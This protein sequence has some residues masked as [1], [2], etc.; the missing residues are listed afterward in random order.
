VP[1]DNCKGLSK[2]VEK[3]SAMEGFYAVKC[4]GET[5]PLIVMAAGYM[6]L[7]HQD[8]RWQSHYVQGRGLYPMQTIQQN[9]PE[10]WSI[11]STELLP[12]L[13]D[14]VQAVE[15]R[16]WDNLSKHEQMDAYQAQL[17]YEQR[18]IFLQDSAILFPMFP[19][20][21]VFLQLPIFHNK[22]FLDWL[23]G[24]FRTDILQ[25]Q[26]MA[27]LAYATISAQFQGRTVLDQ[28]REALG[29][30][31][32]AT[33][34]QSLQLLYKVCE[35]IRQGAPA[36]SDVLPLAP[37]PVELPA[38]SAGQPGVVAVTTVNCLQQLWDS[39]EGKFLGCIPLRCY[40]ADP[41]YRRDDRSVTMRWLRPNPMV[42]RWGSV[43][44][45]MLEM[46][47]QVRKLTSSDDDSFN[48]GSRRRAA[49]T[50]IKKWSDLL[51]QTL[52][53]IT[54]VAELAAA[55]RDYSQPDNRS[56]LTYA[57]QKG[58]GKRNAEGELVNPSRKIE[59]SK[60]ALLFL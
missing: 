13:N 22:V 33:K 40:F 24:D 28:A 35:L 21:D 5:M 12:G 26:G 38:T 25:L 29:I 10:V 15:A 58:N 43:K 30:S 53:E 56:M 60:F 14:W 31:I 4:P 54:T 57:Q 45:M 32:S 34:E 42:R 50:V 9:H 46:D 7:P 47:K 8:F 6:A 51:K 41:P 55:F 59:R 19:K 48:G 39:W 18:N 44:K 17:Q 27:E 23:L 49:N 11:I 20:S 2:H 16:G 3:Q 1:R 37:T 36:Q 52:C